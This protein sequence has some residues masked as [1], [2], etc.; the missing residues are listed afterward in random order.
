MRYIYKHIFTRITRLFLYFLIYVIVSAV[1]IAVFGG[2]YKTYGLS[3]MDAISVSFDLF[4]G[5]DENSGRFNSTLI[6]I[7]YV[8]RDVI[9]VTWIGLSLSR[10]LSPLNPI[11]FTNAFTWIPKTDDQPGTFS[12]CYWLM[13]QSGRFLYD[14][15]ILV[16]VPDT[17]KDPGRNHM[18]KL[19]QWNQ[20]YSLARGIRYI[21]I[22]ED[23]DK[24]YGYL[25]DSKMPLVVM[26]R[27][28]DEGGRMY[29]RSK[30]YT[31][32]N[33]KKSSIFISILKA[34]YCN[35]LQLKE[36]DPRYPYVQFDNFNKT[37]ELQ[38]NTEKPK[39]DGK[40]I[41]NKLFAFCLYQEI[42]CSERIKQKLME[43]LR[44]IW[45]K[46][47]KKLKKENTES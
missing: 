24:L 7:E 37:Y 22:K 35:L 11:Y 23:C 36:D 32:D 30:S 17:S 45:Q 34:K 46:L 26:I 39:V 5:I 43:K 4:F 28:T 15:E 31:A 2:F 42:P 14:V 25:F 33:C 29:Y 8:V 44:R 1:L 47:L 38:G 19:W 3:L 6:A 20:H 18:E 40:W 41:Q 27:G 10:L 16:F 12:F 9:L 13:L 21:D